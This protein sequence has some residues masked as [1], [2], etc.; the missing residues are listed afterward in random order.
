MS[1]IDTSKE[2][3]YDGRRREPRAGTADEVL[4]HGGILAIVKTTERQF[5]SNETMKP[6]MKARDFK[7]SLR[8]NTPEGWFMN[9]WLWSHFG[10]STWQLLHKNIREGISS[11]TSVVEEDGSYYFPMPKTGVGRT[12]RFAGISAFNT[13]SL[14]LMIGK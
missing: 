1:R 7:Y 4:H 2:G 13:M 14:M 5:P 9:S 6:L 8:A 3:L 12:T 11:N 10:L